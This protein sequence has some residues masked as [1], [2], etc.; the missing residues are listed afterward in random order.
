MDD[1]QRLLKKYRTK[2]FKKGEIIL[3]QGEVPECAYV[4]KSGIVKSYNL[5]LSGEEKP[6]GFDVQDDLFPVAWVYG[7][8][9]HVQFYYEAFTEVELHCVPTEEI[10]KYLAAHIKAQSYTLDRLVDR[11]VNMQLRINALEQSKASLKVLNTIHFLC[12]RFGTEVKTNVIRIELPLT[13]QDLANFIGLTRETTGIELK[14]LQDNGILNR[15]KQFMIVK[16]DKLN[17]LL[18]EDYGL[19]IVRNLKPPK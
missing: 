15:K 18:D 3:V 19:G 16:T 11:Y 2:R 6:I 14:K 13:Q 5:T 4:V 17:E 12:L 1:F 10:R 7:K 8:V 9:E